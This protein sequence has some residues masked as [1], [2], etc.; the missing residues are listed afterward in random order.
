MYFFTNRGNQFGRGAVRETRASPR[1]DAGENAML[2][3]DWLNGENA[4]LAP[5]WLKGEGSVTKRY[6]MVTRGLRHMGTW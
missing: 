2:A 6:L 4:M 5:D 3:P 1:K